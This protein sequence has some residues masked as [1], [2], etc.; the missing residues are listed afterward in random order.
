MTNEIKTALPKNVVP[1]DCGCLLYV[2]SPKHHGLTLH[3]KDHRT[4]PEIENDEEGL[5]VMLDWQAKQIKRLLDLCGEFV[6]ALTEMAQKGL[7]PRITVRFKEA[8][9]T[10]EKELKK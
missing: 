5:E 9:E 3:C 8:V 4:K 6:D 2:Q 10:L 1:L 7:L